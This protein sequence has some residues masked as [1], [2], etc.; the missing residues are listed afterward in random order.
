M[1]L[2]LALENLCRLLGDWARG[3]RDKRTGQVRPIL[4]EI[5]QAWL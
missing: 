3:Q 5:K 2:L 1:I 4:D